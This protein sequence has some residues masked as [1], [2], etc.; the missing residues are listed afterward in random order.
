M[1]GTGNNVMQSA[2]HCGYQMVEAY[3]YMYMYK[4]PFT[5]ALQKCLQH[6]IFYYLAIL[7]YR[8]DGTSDQWTDQAHPGLP[9]ATQLLA[10]VVIGESPSK[11]HNRS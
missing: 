6:C 7:L 3:T 1:G 11:T 8:T 4:L 5:V 2:A 9:L 10:R